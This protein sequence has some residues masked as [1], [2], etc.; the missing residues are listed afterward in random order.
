LAAGRPLGRSGKTAGADEQLG[1][2]AGQIMIKLG[3]SAGSALFNFALVLIISRE[4]KASEAGAFFEAIAAFLILSSVAQLGADIG[5]VRMISRQR[6]LGHVKDLSRTMV[7]ALVPTIVLGSLFGFLVW[8]YAHDIAAIVAHGPHT[9]AAAQYMRYLAPFLPVFAV[10]EI[11]LAGIRGFGS[12]L[13]IVIIDDLGTPALRP[14]LAFFALSFGLGS[15]ALALAWGL[16]LTIGGAA[17]LVLLVRLLRHEDQRRLEDGS[18]EG[19]SLVSLAV[20]FWRFSSAR[21]LADVFSTSVTWLDILLI[22]TFATTGQAGVYAAASRFLLVGT[23][24]LSA[25]ILVISPYISACLARN[26]LS[27]ARNIFQTSTWWVMSLSWPTYI[28]IALFSRLLLSVFGVQFTAG[29]TA[30]TILAFAQLVNMATGPVSAVLLMAGYSGWN[31]ANAFAALVVNIGLNAY[32]IPR[33]GMNGA[34][35]A[36]AASIVVKNV[37]ALVEVWALLGLEPFGEGFFVVVVAAT[38]SFGVWGAVAKTFLHGDAA[39]LAVTLVVSVPVYLAI[40][41]RQ[42]ETLQIGMFRT[43]LLWRARRGDARD[44]SDELTEL[45]SQ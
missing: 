19:A 5:V 33:Y 4:L 25:T 24:A 14:I 36:F 6:A 11:A 30:L 27:S 1:R 18:V 28:L 42:R 34:A 22:G 45:T 13:P 39:A 3:G 31:M 40:V 26:D 20:S 23:L 37:S 29:H 15:L 41:W 35:I 7:I 9:E 38:V 16:P 2:I 8:T 17:A 10:A 44:E 12:V 32:L 21:A 43:A